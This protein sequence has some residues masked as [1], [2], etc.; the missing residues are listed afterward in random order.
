MKKLW[1]STLIATVLLCVIAP[2]GFRLD[3]ILITLQTFTIFLVAS[4][5]GK[6][7]GLYAT[8]LYIAIG[9][10]GVPVFGGH[11]GGWE[12]LIGNTAGFIWAFPFVAYGLGWLCEKYEPHFLNYLKF[13]FLA[14]IVL[15]II[16]FLVLKFMEPSVMLFETFQRLIP[17]LL[18]KTIGGGI[19]GSWLVRTYGEK[20]RG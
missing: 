8:L 20:L 11:S 19:L 17:G 13:F 4:V 16:G 9:A 10:L 1:L 12:K 6:Q 14:H 5:L 3:G 15:I 2:I 7:V 18:L